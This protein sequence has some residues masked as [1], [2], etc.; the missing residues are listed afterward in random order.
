[1]K[2]YPKILEPLHLRCAT[3]RNRVVM[4]SM[5]TGLEG[6][7]KEPV[8]YHRLARF[9][10]ERAEGG[11]GLI[12][13]G[14]FSPSPEGLLTP[15]ERVMTMK[16]APELRRVTDAVHEGGGHIAMQLLHAGRYSNLDRSVA[17]SAIISPISRQRV[18]PEPMSK[19]L[20][21]RT[22][23][24]FVMLARVAREAGFDG[25]EI[26]SSEGYLL[27]QFIVAHTNERTDEYG[28][29]YENRIR[30]PLEVLKAV[31]AETGDD[32]MIIFRVSMLDLIPNGSTQAEVF[33]LAER[34][35]AKADII[36][37][38]IGWHEA[39]I[40]TIATSVP[41]AGYAWATR[42]VRQHLRGKG[43]ETPLIAAN[44][45]NH[46]DVLEQ[47][48]Q[49]GD[50][51]LV[52]MA[53]PWLSDANFVQKVMT[54]NAHLI[55]ICIGCNEACL[56]NIFTGRTASCMVNPEACHEEELAAHPVASPK[57]IAV[58]GGG[59]A[60][61]SSAITL[62]RRGHDVTLYEQ[63]GH[64]G[65]QFNLAMRIPG[66][67][68]FQS[69]IRYWTN[70]LESLPN[71]TVLLNTKVTWEI[72]MA[73]NFDEVV[74]ATGCEPR[75]K[76]DDTIPGI[77]G[78]PNVFTYREAILNPEKIGHRVAVI[79]TGGIGFDVSELLVADHQPLP[80]PEA[81]AKVDATHFCKKW[82]IQ[83][84][85]RLPGG[86]AKPILEKPMRQVTM[87]QRSKGKAGTTLQPTTG[88]IH[89]LELRFAG[90]NE[91]TGANYTSFD[92]SVLTYVVDGVEAALEVDAVVLCTGQESNTELLRAI[93]ESTKVHGVGGCVTTK[94]LDA[95]VAI[96]QGHK[97]AI[98]L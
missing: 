73:G 49:D 92:G 25:V 62:A 69:S 43:I 72:L 55:N 23:E 75:A 63:S 27:N 34:V 58:V 1:M 76:S 89:R 48:L 4:G 95:R 2:A 57:R 40:P 64:L 6:L 30:F 60:G 46:P 9:Y 90:V 61:A 52:G 3:L 53:R 8:P 7:S 86:V 56:D 51:D 38:G 83:Q 68:E 14:G 19:D 96:L 66:K 18:V 42:A 59:P 87:F 11:A 22:T 45:M 31:R 50:A 78:K 84:A 29:S 85:I 32:F 71:V 91:V 15:D 98:K 47:V 70:T 97:V 35:S 10:K 82:G 94:R 28:G 44:R 65:G 41:R 37:T 26:M 16:E 39:R 93:P 36:N 12:I 88:W 20:I 21:T 5:H 54:G 17:P 81:F 24:D 80:P 74:V 67:S 77:E 33:E 13:T 79:G